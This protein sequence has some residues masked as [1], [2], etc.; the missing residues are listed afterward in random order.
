MR[1]MAAW[2]RFL[3]AS[4]FF[5]LSLWFVKTFFLETVDELGIR[6]NRNTIQ[7]PI[8]LLHVGPPK[9]SSSSLQ[10]F[11][12]RNGALL[13]KD[14]YETKFDFP[15]TGLDSPK[16]HVGIARC[17]RA[18]Y[19]ARCNDTLVSLQQYLDTSSSNQSNVIFSSEG[20]SGANLDVL[21]YFFRNFDIKIVVFYRSMYNMQ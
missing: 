14:S 11:L 16:N 4:L 10:T 21:G 15:G 17:I 2:K 12:F 7:K 5:P 20:F 9:T 3:A 1:A 8:A 18:E 6:T 13:R 19:N